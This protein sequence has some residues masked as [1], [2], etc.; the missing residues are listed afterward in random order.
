MIEEKKCP[1]CG[2]IKKSKE[3]SPC[4]TTKSG[5]RPYCKLFSNKKKKIWDKNNVEYNIKYRNENKEKNK[6]YYKEY[7]NENYEMLAEK[8][9]ERYYKNHEKNLEYRKKYREENKE[10]WLNIK[11]NGK[12]KTEKKSIKEEIN[13]IKKIHTHT[14]GDH[15]YKTQLRE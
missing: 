12:K 7:R 2:E 5:L 11:R 6:T 13:T 4:K 15:Y 8:S 3:F 10:K 9:K 14:L 1:I